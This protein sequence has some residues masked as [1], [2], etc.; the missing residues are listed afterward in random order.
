KHAANTHDVSEGILNQILRGLVSV[1]ENIE[2]SPHKIFY[3]SEYQ[4]KL[5]KIQQIIN[6]EEA[7]L[8]LN[9]QRQSSTTPKQ[10]TFLFDQSRQHD[11]NEKAIP[12]DTA[13]DEDIKMVENKTPI[14]RFFS[15]K[16]I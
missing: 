16:I 5:Q 1:S 4:E 10:I 8:K 12:M 9:V 13:L 14:Q 11:K 7:K 2:L 15:S 3:N 6:D